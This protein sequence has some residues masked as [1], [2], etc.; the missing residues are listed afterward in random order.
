MSPYTVWL[1]IQSVNNNEENLTCR[2]NFTAT[3]LGKMRIFIFYFIFLTPASKCRIYIHHWR[4]WH[5]GENDPI[6]IHTEPHKSHIWSKIS[7]VRFNLLHKK[8]FLYSLKMLVCYIAGVTY[9]E[10]LIRWHTSY[11]KYL[12]YTQT[13]NDQFSDEFVNRH[14]SIPCNYLSHHAYPFHIKK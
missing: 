2:E 6:Y 12:M 7:L 13:F 9:Y 1:H 4:W 8:I 11:T 14:Y 5:T 3:F 10:S